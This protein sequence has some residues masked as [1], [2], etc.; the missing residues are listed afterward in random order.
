MTNRRKH[1]ETEKYRRKSDR[2]RRKKNKAEENG[3]KQS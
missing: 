1:I 3:G 2:N